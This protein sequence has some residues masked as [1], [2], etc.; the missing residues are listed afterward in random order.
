MTMSFFAIVSFKKYINLKEQNTKKE[1][2]SLKHYAL[3]I[4]IFW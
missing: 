1:I 2:S 4:Q 3:S